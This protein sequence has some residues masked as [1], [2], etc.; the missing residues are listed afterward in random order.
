MRE[1]KLRGLFNLQGSSFL[2]DT[3]EEKDSLTAEGFV[4][5]HLCRKA[6]LF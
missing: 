4:N 6:F 2:I 5:K 3:W 1:R